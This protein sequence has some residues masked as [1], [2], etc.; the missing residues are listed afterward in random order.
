[1]VEPI[2]IPLTLYRGVT[3]S[4]IT[5]DNA[6]ISATYDESIAKGFTK[7]KCCII[8]FN[9]PVGSKVLFIE[10]ISDSPEEL[11]VYSI[12]AELF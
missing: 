5:P 10:S 12:G 8:V 4:D 1:M 11:E 6:F 3:K 2:P 7:G 9:I